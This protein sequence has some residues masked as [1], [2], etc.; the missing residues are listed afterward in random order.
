MATRGP[1][2]RPT[3]SL[4]GRGGI[5]DAF[6]GGSNLRAML[7]EMRESVYV[8]EWLSVGGETNQSDIGLNLNGSW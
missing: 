2:S 7:G 4:K 1:E 5:L 3:D 8:V 6:R